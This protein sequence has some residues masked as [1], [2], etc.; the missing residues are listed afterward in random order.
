MYRAIVTLLTLTILIYSGVTILYNNIEARLRSYQPVAKV[1]KEE[2]SQK[3]VEAD[4]E[5]PHSSDYKVIATR[6]IFK[7]VL[8]APDTQQI[9]SEEENLK[10]TRL[11]LSLLGTSTGDQEYARAIIVDENKKKQQLLRVGDPI[12]GARIEK[13]SR[14]RVV[15]KVNGKS[16][17]LIIKERKGR[18]GARLQLD[19]GAQAE[20][21]FVPEPRPPVAK[22]RRRVKLKRTE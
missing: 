22:P 12:Q 15:L 2:K 17:V 20:S 18:L 21:S 6:N 4:T 10:E 16:E 7:A 1:T 9:K 13:I 14:G 8:Q 19:R 3:R 11:K 5:K